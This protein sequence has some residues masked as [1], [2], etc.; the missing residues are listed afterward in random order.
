MPD[1]DQL[2]LARKHLDAVEHLMEHADQSHH[3]TDFQ[4]LW[5]SVDGLRRALQSLC[6]H[7]RAN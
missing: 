4:V 3:S 2:D 7:L 1:S 6:A 5:T